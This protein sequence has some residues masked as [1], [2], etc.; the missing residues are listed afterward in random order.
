MASPQ[1]EYYRKARKNMKMVIR[2]LSRLMDPTIERY[3]DEDEISQGEITSLS[4]SKGDF[5][6]Y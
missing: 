4:P 3:F 2:Q 6:D 5:L 1:A